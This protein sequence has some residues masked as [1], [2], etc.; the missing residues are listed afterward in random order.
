[1][2]EGGELLDTVAADRGCF[3]CM[4]GGDDGCSLYI[5][6]NHYSGSGAS[7]GVVLIH[8]VAVPRAGRT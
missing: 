1:V 7:H 2:A 4:L 5:V 8:P 6:A 3:A